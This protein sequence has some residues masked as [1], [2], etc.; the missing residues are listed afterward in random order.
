MSTLTNCLVILLLLSLVYTQDNTAQELIEAHPELLVVLDNYFGCG[1]WDNQVC[2][3][4]SKNYFF[5][6]KGICC[7]V[8]P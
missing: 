2:I 5:N 1:K 3:E 6:A 7:E 4:C 8:S